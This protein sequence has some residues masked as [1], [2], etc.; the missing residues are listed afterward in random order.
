L[1]TILRL[2]SLSYQNKEEVLSSFGTEEEKAKMER[3]SIHFSFRKTY[4][5]YWIIYSHYQLWA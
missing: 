4:H 5:S 3:D 1:L 2:H